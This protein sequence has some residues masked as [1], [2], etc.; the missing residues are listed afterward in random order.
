MISYCIII[1]SYNENKNLIS[2][3][4][5]LLRETKSSYNSLEAIY[6]VACNENVS[7]ESF[8]KL[9]EEFSNNKKIFILEEKF[10]EG[11]AKAINKALALSK[12]EI[13]FV[14][15]ADAFAESGFIDNFLKTFE[16]DRRIGGITLRCTP[17]L[18]NKKLPEII[19]AHL[20]LLL[21]STLE[22][23]DKK[24]EVTQLGND[25]YAFKKGI[26]E[27]LPD[28]VINED[29]YIALQIL[30]KGFIIKYLKD[31][32]SYILATKTINDII[33]QRERIILGHRL[34]YKIT[35][36]HINSIKLLIFISPFKALRIIRNYIS[37]NFPLSIFIFLFITVL[38]SISTIS[39]YIKFILGEDFLKWRI[40]YTTKEIHKYIPSD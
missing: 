36:K 16:S 21:N 2:L 5:Y 9:T 37:N 8:I 14:H 24:G 35:K 11:K 19:S 26:I 3:I 27:K 7:D 29:A 25:V 20:W 4:K 6:V 17:I 40:A 12:A 22:E 30:E 13:A 10:R 1:P 31:S 18:I 33:K 23:L 32:C 15:S 39:G 34:N 28:N 38:E